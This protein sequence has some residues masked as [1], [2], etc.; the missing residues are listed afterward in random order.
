MALPTAGSLLVASIGAQ[1]PGN[2]LQMVGAAANSHQGM[3][4]SAVDIA[5]TSLAISTTY[6]NT[7]VVIW[8]VFDV[9]QTG[10]T[11][12][13]VGTC[14]VDGVTQSGEAHN[15]SLRNTCTQMWIAT[16]AAAGA[17]TIKL[18]GLKSGGSDT[19]STNA[20]HTKWHALVF[21]P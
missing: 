21:G 12:V 6:P 13:F 19:V 2:A 20:T 8:G 14:Q 5:G 17:H 9:D 10:T 1:L 16:L 4:G 3:T 11:S 18:Q 7:K 15:E